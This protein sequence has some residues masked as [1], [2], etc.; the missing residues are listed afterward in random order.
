M[1]ACKEESGRVAERHFTKGGQFTE[2]A[3]GASGLG[4]EEVAGEVPS[5]RTQTIGG[6]R[7]EL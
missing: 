2:K 4:D 5:L 3:K 6:V 1:S 7:S